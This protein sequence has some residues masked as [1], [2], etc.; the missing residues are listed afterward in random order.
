MT[1]FQSLTALASD[2]IVLQLPR[3]HPFQFA[4]YYAALDKG[5]YRLAGLD[6]EIIEGRVDAVSAYATTE[7]WQLKQLRMET[8]IISPQTYGVDFYSD[9]LFISTQLTSTQ[10]TSTQFTSTQFTSTQEV[11]KHPTRVKR[12]AGAS[13]RGWE[14]DLSHTGVMIDP[15]FSFDGIFYEPEATT[16]FPWLKTA[17]GAGLTV[18]VAVFIGA[19]IILKFKRK[20]TTEKAQRHRMV[21]DHKNNEERLRNII[22]HSSDLF[23]SHTTTHHFTYLSPQC[24][25]FFDCEPEEAMT[26]WTEFIT[27]NPINKK[28]HEATE[29]AIRTGK[30]Q[31]PYELELKSKKGRIF[32]VEVHESPVLKNGKTEEIVGI[33]T[34][35]TE[36]HHTEKA[37][38]ESEEKYRRIFQHSV[39]G[40]FQSTPE[41]RFTTVNP[42]FA[43]MLGYQS[44]QQLV[45]EISDI[46]SQ[47]YANPEDRRRYQQTLKKQGSV[48]NFEL[49]VQCKDGSRKWV[50]NST[51]AYFDGEGKPTHYE[52]IVF[53]V[54]QQKIAETLLQESEA[55]FRFLTDNMADIVWTTD[56]D[57]RTT[58]MSPSAVKMLGFSEEE[59]KSQSL[60]D[61]MTPESAERSLTLLATEFEKEQ[62]EPQLDQTFTIETE[63]YK[64]DGST[65]WL[66]NKVKWMRDADGTIMGIHGVSRDISERRQSLS[67][68]R[69]SEERYRGVVEDMPG[70]ICCFLPS[71]EITFVNKNYCEYFTKSSQELV[72][73]N[74]QSFIHDSA[75]ES[76]MTNIRALTIDSPI[77]SHEHQVI[78]GNGD[79]TWQRW[80]NRALF[81]SQGKA[82]SYQAIGEDITVQKRIAMIQKA[83]Y[84]IA[85]AMVTTVNLEESFTIIKEEL[86]E[87]IDVNQLF[88]FLYDQK[89]GLE[90]PLYSKD[91][92]DT[93]SGSWKLA[94]FLSKRVKR[95]NKPFLLSSEKIKE[96]AQKDKIDITDKISEVWL[97]LPLFS[98]E[99]FIGTLILQNDDHSG[100]PW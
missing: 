93:T 47:Y 87:L 26:K 14:Y 97:G 94:K 35:I 78:S 65:F 68:L 28:G 99:K 29:E 69:E 53:D 48:E 33:A 71:G 32:R 55:H 22:E 80:T 57:F 90:R 1:F 98:G 31:P 59:R 8:T 76:M 38:Q 49:E 91:E 6:V 12:I 89:S 19:F 39:A 30:R 25:A 24:R 46:S 70:L 11:E 60:A 75:R 41:G 67:A 17:W 23:Y 15:D 82:V 37:L 88:L 100:C 79:I 27:D 40:F 18:V 74:I 34:D 73:S 20:L 85:N 3:K 56:L 51:R 44:P 16:K 42:A 61:M 2:K 13:L 50:S 10:S 83:Q 96:L 52:G 43:R 58:Y 95:E 92:N 63:S 36:R 62:K 86:A 66:E 77:Q 84:N 21:A 4:G 7:P 45:S 54:T 5:F 64:K 9:A 72:G 81:D